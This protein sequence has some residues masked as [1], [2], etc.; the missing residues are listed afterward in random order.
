MSTSLGRIVSVIFRQ[1]LHPGQNQE[2]MVKPP[3]RDWKSNPTPL[4]CTADNLDDQIG[5]G[6]IFSKARWQ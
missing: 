6:F 2:N 5:E 4:F 3:L 1:G